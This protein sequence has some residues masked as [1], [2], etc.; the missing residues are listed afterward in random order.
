MAVAATGCITSTEGGPSSP[1][2]VV[3]SIASPSAQVASQPFN[4][5]DC[6]DV[7]DAPPP[8]FTLETRVQNIVDSSQA[9]T[10]EHMCSSTYESVSPDGPFL[11]L[12]VITFNSAAEAQSHFEI[13]RE[14]AQPTGSA[15]EVQVRVAAPDR[16]AID[17]TG[18]DIAS[19]AAVLQERVIVS[20]HSGK[21]PD[22]SDQWNATDLMRQVASV[23]ERHPDLR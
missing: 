17:I 21:V 9:A 2:V 8:E 16:Y 15:P 4:Q 5:V 11:T 20:A 22:G 12:G 19:Q 13:M 3:Q 10:I 6:Q 18:S 23:I 14:G 7:L 1:V